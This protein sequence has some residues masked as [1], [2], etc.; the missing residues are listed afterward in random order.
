MSSSTSDVVQG[1]YIGTDVSGTVAV[2][3]SW[4]VVASSPNDTVG[5]TANGA[6]NIIS[7]NINA[8]VW[9]G[10][11]NV[12][13]QGNYIGTNTS[14]AGAIANGTGI[15]VAASFNTIGGTTSA[16]R[17]VIA[18][19]DHDG[20]FIDGG[21]SGVAVLGNYIG[22]T[23]LGTAA[24]GNANGIEIDG[25][26]D[27]I[28]GTTGAAR[29]VIAGNNN[30][31]LFIVNGANNNQVQGNFI[32]TTPAGTGALGNGQNGVEIA[33]NSN[34]LGGSV[35]GA[36]NLIS[37]NGNDGLL[38]D[39]SA[40]GNYVQSDYFG[41]SYN[42]SAA[43]GNSGNG[44]EVAGNGNLIG[45]SAS[46]FRNVVSGNAADGILLDPSAS[47]NDVL[48]NFVGT[49]AAG[50]AALG[51]S[52]N[53]VE[54]LGQNNTL[55]GTTAGSRNVISANAQ[56]GVLLAGAASGNQV[57]GNYIGTN[58]AGT[59]ALGNNANGIEF[60]AGNNAGA[61]NVISG[62]GND[63]VLIGSGVSNVQIL[64]NSV[65]LGSAGNTPLANSANGIDVYGANNTIGGSSNG[66]RNVISG[67]GND[68]VFIEPGASGVAVQGNYIGTDFTGKLMVG[69]SANGIE[70]GDN[71]ALI[72]G[73]I[74][75]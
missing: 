21:V 38:L 69:N 26:Y 47:G 62:N 20:I 6:R 12:A 36:R 42:G 52:A 18:G 37:S 53:G 66:A 13:V 25:F 50:S 58:S 67:N 22:T 3:N 7:G 15:E 56:D 28:G 70:V 72:G 14:G 34:N 64:G 24:L 51:N 71:N 2:P 63:G 1:N 31:G 9:L 4:G 68:G 61:R 41:T 44:I 35:T 10:A 17:N 75:R 73:T 23:T 46:A 29:N 74:R 43:L 39:G 65:G 45:Y 54:I 33:G 55:G 32:G 40:S 19:N 11:S 60:L 59:A 5:G 30:D 49:N 16:A 57:Q 27:T 48:G 8:G